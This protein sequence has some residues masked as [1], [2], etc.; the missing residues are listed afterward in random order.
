MARSVTFDTEGWASPDEIDGIVRRAS[1]CEAKLDTHPSPAVFFT[2][3]AI[4]GVLYYMARQRT[5][6]AQMGELLQEALF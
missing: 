4:G 1:R 3:G 5:M 6:S 2:L